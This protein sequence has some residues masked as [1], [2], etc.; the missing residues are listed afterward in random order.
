MDAL[1]PECRYL[2]PEPKIAVRLKLWPQTL[3]LPEEAMTYLRE[4]AKF[5]GTLALI[6]VTGLI[7]LMAG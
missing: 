7:L 5:L 2:Q 3:A 1:L 6:A 4:G